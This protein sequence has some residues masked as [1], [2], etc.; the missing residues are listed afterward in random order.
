MIES[1]FEDAE[2]SEAVGS[3]HSDFGF[4]V[5][6]LDNAAGEQLL[7]TEVVEDQLAMFAQGTGDLLH[8]FD[9]GAHHLAAP[10]VEEFTSP[11]GGVVIPEL[12]EGFLQKVCAH[13]L[14]VVAEQIGLLT[15]SISLRSRIGM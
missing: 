3:S 12:L 15:R 13:S 10:F 2:G 4:V 5:E 14:Q 7:S 6:P 9:A 11:G 8:R 1:E